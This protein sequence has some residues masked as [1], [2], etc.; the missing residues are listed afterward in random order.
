[1]KDFDAFELAYKNGYEQGYLDAKKE[2]EARLKKLD[3]LYKYFKELEKIIEEENNMKM[4]KDINDVNNFKAAV[5]QCKGDVIIRHNTRHEEF[6]MKSLFS[7]Y[8]GLAELMK[9][10][11]DEYEIFCMNPSD[12]VYIINYFHDKVGA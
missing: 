9:D 3:E 8:L 5:K 4:L 7:E 10:H 12:E 2:Y 11:G 1:M 6:N